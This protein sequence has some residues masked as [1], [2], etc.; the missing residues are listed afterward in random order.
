MPT[1]NE[2][3]R[4]FWM[5]HRDIS[6]DGRDLFVA[7]KFAGERRIGEV[8]AHDLDRLRGLLRRAGYACLCDH[9]NDPRM[10]SWL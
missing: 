7:I 9:G 2:P 4:V 10:E 1:P 5:I 6:D 8:S 3:A